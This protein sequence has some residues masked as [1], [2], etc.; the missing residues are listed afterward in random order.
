MS[1]FVLRRWDAMW[2]GV[3]TGAMSLSHPVRLS[4]H[5]CCPTPNLLMS[6]KPTFNIISEVGP[7]Q[8]APWC[9]DLKAAFTDTF[10]HHLHSLN[11]YFPISSDPSLQG[12]GLGP[13]SHFRHLQDSKRTREERKR[14]FLQT[15]ATPR[16][17]PPTEFHAVAPEVK[18]CPPV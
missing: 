11:W 6:S 14:L 17:R 3:V 16:L 15:A 13:G 10:S 12:K 1:P 5:V 8:L 18:S 2:R 9:R 4:R 7:T